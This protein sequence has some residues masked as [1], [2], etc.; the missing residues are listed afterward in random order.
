MHERAAVPSW[1]IS[2]VKT[3]RFRA[4]RAFACAAAAVTGA[5]AIAG[6]AA[7]AQTAARLRIDPVKALRIQGVS[8][9]ESREFNARIAAVHAFLGALAELREPRPPECASVYSNMEGR[10]N[11]EAATVQGG[12]AIGFMTGPP[13]GPCPKVASTVIQIRLNDLRW[14][15]NCSREVRD[16]P[17]CTVPAFQPGPGGFRRWEGRQAFYVWARGGEPLLLPASKDEYLRA[18]E[19]EM[20]ARIAAGEGDAEWLRKEIERIRARRAALTPEQGALPA[21]EQVPEAGKEYLR[22]E[23]GAG[24]CGPGR[25]IGTP[26]T[27]LLRST[28]S[29]VDAETLVLRTETGR[30]VGVPVEAHEHKLRVL[31]AFDFEGLVRVVTQ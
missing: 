15:Y 1:R 2:A 10:K 11:V 20:Q 30:V 27:G 25:T 23:P 21:C 5:L 19:A 7:N 14:I 29:P 28:P 3:N 31:G 12:A 18:W 8:E 13:G 16:R 6:V 4:S 24:A 22:W 9:A 17:F 26:N